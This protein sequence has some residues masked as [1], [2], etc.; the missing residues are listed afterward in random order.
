MPK[1]GTTWLAEY[2][3]KSPDVF[4]PRMKELQVFNRLFVPELY[5]WMNPYFADTLAKRVWDLS[6]G[7]RNYPELI[8]LMAEVLTIPYL[9]DMLAKMKAYRRLFNGRLTGQSVFGEFSTTYCLLP[10]NGLKYLKDAFPEPKFVLMIRDPIN[11]YWS[12]LKHEIRQNKDF[13]PVSFVPKDTPE[14]EFSRMANYAEI[15]PRIWKMLGKENVYILFYES[16]FVEKNNEPL[17]GL[18][19]FLG[20]EFTEPDFEK[21]VYAGADI[22]LPTPLVSTL[23]D[24]FE[25]QYRFLQQE[26]SNLPK[27]IRLS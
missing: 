24:R 6:I 23:R 1:T 20:I 9:E 10:E 5:D 26:F 14:T 21:I 8:A 3:R 13:D 22:E 27:G 15:L 11:R 25:P 12:H 16:L 7:S 2:L 4:I 19:N 18:T 17:R